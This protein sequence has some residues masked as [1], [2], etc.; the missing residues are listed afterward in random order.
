MKAAAVAVAVRFVVSRETRRE[1]AKVRWVGSKA[2]GVVLAAVVLPLG[3]GEESERGLSE[4][5]SR[6]LF[7]GVF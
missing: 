1:P 7:G 2:E 6:L 3:P 4:S 5:R